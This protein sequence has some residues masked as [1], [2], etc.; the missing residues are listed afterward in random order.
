MCVK[1]LLGGGPQGIANLNF[2]KAFCGTFNEKNNGCANVIKFL[3]D[4]FTVL[5]L[6]NNVK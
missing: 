2:Y 1:L 5:C 3:V 6:N 4:L